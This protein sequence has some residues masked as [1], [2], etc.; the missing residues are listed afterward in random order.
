MVGNGEGCGEGG[1]LGASVGLMLGF[2]VGATDGLPDGAD[3]GFPEG[4]ADFTFDGA[5][6]MVG[7]P[8]TDETSDLHTEHVTGHPSLTV[9]PLLAICA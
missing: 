7:L 4:A 5:A 6:L 8:V 3:V 1:L 2:P 9:L